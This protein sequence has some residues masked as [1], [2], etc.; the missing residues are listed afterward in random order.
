[1]LRTLPRQTH[2]IHLHADGK[3]GYIEG[4]TTPRNQMPS[5]QIK[6]NGI[7]MKNGK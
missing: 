4:P 7:L 3:T 1:M 2:P 5:S 6:E